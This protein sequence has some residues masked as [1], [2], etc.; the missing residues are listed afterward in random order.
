M[1]AVATVSERVN[2]VNTSTIHKLVEAIQRDPANAQTRWGATTRWQT[3]AVT[4]TEVVACEVSGRRLARNFRLRTDEPTELGGTNLHA[5]PQEYLM[6]AFNSCMMV[7][8]VALS[9][10]EGIELESVEI[11]SS[12]DIDLRGFL[13]LDTNVKPG[14][15][16]IH[17]TV[18]IKGNGTPEQFQK[19]HQTVMATSP[20]RFNIANPI[21]LT[22]DLRVA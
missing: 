11:E 5:N 8:Y 7:G 9:S 10:L 13:G 1:S 3:G 17:Y 2:G 14:Y 16:S 21:K 15:D 18:R 4:E 22:S 6:A 12:G 20:N 19:I